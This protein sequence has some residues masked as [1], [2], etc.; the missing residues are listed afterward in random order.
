MIHHTSFLSRS[1]DSANED[2]ETENS[3]S[4]KSFLAAATTI[5][6]FAA[7][8]L[9][10]AYL[11]YKYPDKWWLSFFSVGIINLYTLPKFLRYGNPTVIK[12]ALVTNLTALSCLSLGGLS[13]ACYSLSLNIVS[14]CK[15]H[16]FTF[17]LFESFLL[18]GLIGYGFPF[19]QGALQKAYCFLHDDK[20]QERLAV[21]YEQFHD[22]PEVGLGFLQGNLWQNF[23]L[24]L[25][26]YEPD[27]ILSFCQRFD[28]TL[29]NYVCSMVAAA[30]KATS[31]D[32]FNQI[33]NS[34]EQIAETLEVSKEQLSEEMKK[35]YF[36]I[37][38]FALQSLKEE[39]IQ[40]A[41]QSLLTKATIIIPS[42]CSEEHFLEM[43]QT[44]HLLDATNELIDKFLSLMD[45]WDSL[46]DE[47]QRISEDVIQ[48]KLDIQ[49][50]NLKQLSD[51]EEKTL[52][53]EYETLNKEY[54]QLRAGI[55]EV[56]T[57]K[58]IWQNIGILW[59]DETELPFE[60]S[61]D[62]IHFLHNQTLLKEIENI[63][64]DL[65]LVGTRQ[66]GDATLIS[67]LQLIKNKIITIHETNKEIEDEE[68][69][70]AITY[71][72]ANK[73]FIQGDFEDLQLWLGLDSPHDLEEV[74]E[75]IGLGTEKD[76]YE[77]DILPALSKNDIRNN[78]HTFIKKA[79]KPLLNSQLQP[80]EDIDEAS[81]VGI[82]KEKIIRFI[83]YAISSGL[84]LAPVFIH[85]Y[86]GATGFAIGFCFFTLKHFN[87][88]GTQMIAE[89][90][91]DFIDEFP[92]L[93][94]LT[95][96]QRVFTLNT[97][98]IQA[99]NNFVEADIFS[100]MRIINNQIL[101]SLFFPFFMRPTPYTGSFIQAMALSNE[102]VDMMI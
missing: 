78:L 56:Y 62:L 18:T 70:S 26:L 12:M 91:N 46:M 76:L 81:A 17:A 28:I 85:P 55:E 9:S 10:S 101:C 102:I 97:R 86:V 94:R 82:T 34:M 51:D 21:L 88:P 7:G 71:L 89:A 45:S 13:T 36:L 83:Y 41:L 29:P 8:I 58:R 77:N 73:G 39:N 11:T 1:I 100:Q 63:H 43:F 65:I 74:L 22:R 68:D 15:T 61:L 6:V 3:L 40:S 52:Y 96:N 57:N 72:A 95:L 37:L 20:I 35:N 87:F 19:F 25:S 75:K 27:F 92:S 14:A 23:I 54:V 31:L 67:D 69:I 24:N 5:T 90:G 4:I 47:Y 50:L 44:T 53:D 2:W 30:S 33:L 59:T 48:L 64:R 49:K 98:Q 93:I 38:H 32:Y 80:E 60:R 66:N 16:Q 42:A 99:A 79:P 84:I